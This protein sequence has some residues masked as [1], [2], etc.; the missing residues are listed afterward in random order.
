VIGYC[1][2]SGLGDLAQRIGNELLAKS[3]KPTIRIPSGWLRC[4]FLVVTLTACRGD[5]LTDSPAT[6]DLSDKGRVGIAAVWAVDLTKGISDSSD[7]FTAVVKGLECSSG[8][9][10]KVFA[11]VIELG[12][13]KIVVTFLVTPPPKLG[14]NEFH[15]CQGSF[16]VPY[17]VK[18]NEQIGNRRLIDGSC[19]QEP[20]AHSGY[21]FPDAVRWVQ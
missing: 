13:E 9:D 2:F 1:D 19:Q 6:N 21:C 12:E 18:L 20:A 14:Q 5:R 3:P 7:S 4:L 11:P 15:T 8:I 16:G 10:G 17:Q